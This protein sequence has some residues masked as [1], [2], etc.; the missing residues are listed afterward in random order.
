MEKS[1]TNEDVMT[2]IN[3]KN[4]KENEA[5]TICASSTNNIDRIAEKNKEFMS[6]D[7]KPILEM[8]A[9][10]DLTITEMSNSYSMY[11]IKADDET[12]LFS[13]N[14]FPLRIIVEVCPSIC[15]TMTIMNRE[16]NRLFINKGGLRINE[17]GEQMALLDLIE[18]MSIL[19][20]YKIEELKS[21]DEKRHKQHKIN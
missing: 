9:G 19:T 7:I 13:S 10:L 8:L 3:T 6:Y 5:N 1:K 4:S 14:G 2:S 18:R 17:G 11:T 20:T 16:N 21:K 15:V 12:D